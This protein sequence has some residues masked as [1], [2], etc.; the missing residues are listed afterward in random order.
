M[1]AKTTPSDLRILAVKSVGRAGPFVILDLADA[2]RSLGA[3]VQTFNLMPPGNR[4]L[5]QTDLLKRAVEALATFKPHFVFAYGANNHLTYTPPGAPRQNLFCALGVPNVSIFYD[6]PLHSTIFSRLEY[7]QRPELIHSFVWD[8]VL[9]DDF[10]RAGHSNVSYLPIATN[11]KIYRPVPD[12]PADLAA[13]SAEISFVGSYTYPREKALIPLAETGK[14]AV[15]GHDWRLA[16]HPAIRAAVR[17]PVNNRTELV[18][19]YRNSKININLTVEQGVSSLNMR[20]FDCAASGGFLISDYKTDFETLFGSGE[21]VT[22]ADP[23]ELPALCERYLADPISRAEIARD[24][25]RRVLTTHDYPT[26]ARAILSTLA[27]RG[28][29]DPPHWFETTAPQ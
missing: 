19:V 25:R 12:S 22:F 28:V 23:A 5:V 4:P 14:L 1:T 26:R 10:A 3:D 2:F 9:A 17:R 11:T 29:L 20:V 7:G 27:D 6:S 16:T 24:A 18:K 13:Y 21:Y 15:W 8:R